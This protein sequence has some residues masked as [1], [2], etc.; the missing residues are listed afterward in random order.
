MFN[1]KAAKA[2]T[3]RYIMCTVVFI[4]Y[5]FLGGGREQ[6]CNCNLQPPPIQT[7]LMYMCANGKMYRCL[8][9]YVFSFLWNKGK[10]KANE[11]QKE[12][13]WIKLCGFCTVLT[14]PLHLTHCWSLSPLSHRHIT[15]RNIQPKEKKKR[16]LKIKIKKLKRAEA[17]LSL[18]FCL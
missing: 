3:Y 10:K 16:N 14:C 5:Y 6:V 8:C 2:C 7:L 13:G 9:R 4:I 18:F 17:H 15:E 12:E 1:A 11:K